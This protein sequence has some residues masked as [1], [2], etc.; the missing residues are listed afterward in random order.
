M[1]R[2]V[3]FVGLRVP[4]DVSV[5]GYDDHHHRVHDPPLTTIRQNVTAM[6]ETPST[7]VEIIGTPGQ[8]VHLRPELVCVSTAPCR[9]GANGIPSGLRY[10]GERRTALNGNSRDAN[11]GLSRRGLRSGMKISDVL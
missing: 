7:F 2:A 5:I 6:S 11:A 4:Q 8:G 10:E 9:A 1:V 3:R